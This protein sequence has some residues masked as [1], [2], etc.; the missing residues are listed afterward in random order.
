MTLLEGVARCCQTS[1]GVGHRFG[2]KLLIIKKT[3]MEEA[4]V[5]ETPLTIFN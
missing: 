1:E 2:Q 3:K 4:M 5:S